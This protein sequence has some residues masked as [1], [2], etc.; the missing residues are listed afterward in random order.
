MIGALAAR[1]NLR[2]KNARQ[3]IFEL[4]KQSSTQNKGKGQRV[5]HCKRN[6]LKTLRQVSHRSVTFEIILATLQDE[7][8]MLPGEGQ[9]LWRMRDT[10]TLCSLLLENRN[11]EATAQDKT[12]NL[13]HHYRSE[14][15][16]VGKECRSR[17]S[18][19]H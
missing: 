1:N 11:Q 14:E 6:P 12:E 15:R 3:E 9:T 10:R 18:P 4:I 17:W 8:C 19:Y 2:V 13:V 16:R 5:S 7:R